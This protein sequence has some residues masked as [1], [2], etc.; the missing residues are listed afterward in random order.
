MAGE[1]FA[2]GT[3]ERGRRPPY[4]VLQ[5]VNRWPAHPDGF[6]DVYEEYVARMLELGTAVV[7]AM[8]VALLGEEAGRGEVFVRATRRSWWV[9]R[10]I[11][12]PPLP[13]RAGAGEGGHGEM[14]SGA[15]DEGVSCGAHTDYGCLT[16]LLADETKGALQVQERGGEGWIAADPVEGAFVVNVGDMMERWTN[17]LWA[18]TRHRVVHRGDGFRVSG[19][20]GWVF[21]GFWG[22]EGVFL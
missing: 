10:A 22:L 6:R 11:G 20:L 18:S 16:L 19:K 7:R 12:Y 8:G 9:M 2:R 21:A 4:A 17:G 3:G 5:G 14:E 1:P 15:E 13:A